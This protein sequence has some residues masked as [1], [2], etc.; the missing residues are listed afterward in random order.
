MCRE[1]EQREGKGVGCGSGCVS[2]APAMPTKQHRRPAYPIFRVMKDIPAGE[3]PPAQLA[4]LLPCLDLEPALLLEI[5]EYGGCR[6]LDIPGEAGGKIAIKAT[7]AAA[8]IGEEEQEPVLQASKFLLRQIAFSPL[9]MRKERLEPAGFTDTHLAILAQALESAAKRQTDHFAPD[10]AAA[11]Q[12]AVASARAQAAEDAR[13]KPATL[14]EFVSAHAKGPALTAALSGVCR[15]AEMTKV[16]ARLLLWHV[17]CPIAMFLLLDLCNRRAFSEKVGLDSGNRVGGLL[18]MGITA[19][20]FWAMLSVLG[21]AVVNPALVLVDLAASW[22]GARELDDTFVGMY[23][24]HPEKMAAAQLWLWAWLWIMAVLSGLLLNL[25]GLGDIGT[26]LGTVRAQH[27]L[28]LLFVRART[29]EALSP[30]CP[31]ASARDGFRDIVVDSAGGHIDPGPKRDGE[32]AD[33]RAQQ[34]A[35]GCGLG[36]KRDRSGPRILRSV[37]VGGPV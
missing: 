33:D 30:G 17:A 32:V 15:C 28:R 21:C 29:N 14:R 19:G 4:P 2:C 34:N 27:H 26:S 16:S 24:R 8:G 18:C 20:E 23:T 1:H 5:L 3:P 12:A 13:Q 31:A 7:L 25:C 9:D 22:T 37:P 10:P 36:G 6:A 11:R 35:A